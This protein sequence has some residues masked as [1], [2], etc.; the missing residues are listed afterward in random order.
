MSDITSLADLT[1]DPHNAR[2][3]TP[4]NVGMI[5]RALGEV[6]AARSIVIDENGVVLAGN[7]TIEAAAQAGI[8]HVQVVDADGETI[9][10]VRRRGLTD[11][12]KTKLALFDNRSSDLS[13]WDVGVLAELAQETNLSGLFS[14]EELA[15]LIAGVAVAPGEH[16]DDAPVID[17]DAPTRVQPGEVWR[18]GEH[19]IACLDSTDRVNVERWAKSASFVIA[20]P[21]YGIDIV[22]ADVSVGG[23]AKYDYPFGGV[24]RGFVGGATA[25]KAATGR[26]Y[27]EETHGKARGLGS[28]GGAKPFGSRGDH[29]VTGSIG[30]DNMIPAG[31]YVPVIGDDSTDTAIEAALLMLDLFPKAAQFWWGANNYANVLPP[32]TCWIVWDKENTGNFAD[33]ELAWSNHKSAVR[34]FKHMWNGLMKASERGDRRVH[35]TQKPVAL[36]LWLFEKYGKPG[37]IILDPFLGSGPS[38]KAAHRLGDRTVVGFELSPHYC[39]YLIGWAEAEGLPCAP[40]K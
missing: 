26:Y 27:I 31:L 12:Q 11:E 36:C 33:A 30:G 35:P 3:H 19:I 25:H 10:A 23:G 24:K 17:P 13:E 37:D 34:I 20:D 28:V 5:E 6:G 1:P 38:L 8:E 14:D 4:R 21:P 2:R 18:A 9:I 39:D 7:A 29:I 15:A 22:A 32:S 40:L 16:D